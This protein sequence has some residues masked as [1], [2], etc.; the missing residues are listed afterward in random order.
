MFHRFRETLVHASVY[1]VASF[2]QKGVGFLMIPVY[3]HYLSP[4][5]Y[6]ILELID[7]F[8]VLVTM[9]AAMGLG[10]AIVRF[11]HA[12][13]DET[14]KREVA[15]TA[16]A[17]V[18]VLV[19]VLFLLLQGSTQ[20]VSNWIFQSDDYAIYF[21]I[22][23]FTVVLQTLA[24]VPESVLLAQKRS[25]IISAITLLTFVSYLSLNI[26]FIVGLKMGVMGMLLSTVITKV[27]NTSMN[28]WV[29][30]GSFVWSFSVQKFRAMAKFGMPLIP[31]SLAML[32]IHYADRFFVQRYGSADELGLYSL[33]YKF[34]MIL[35]V[36]ISQ[37]IFNIFN[38]LRFEMVDD[39][40]PGAGFGRI[41]TYIFII[42]VYAA[43]GIIVLSPE[44]INI[45]AP[46]DYQGA[47]AVVTPIVVS[48][49]FFGAQNF[50]TSGMFIGYKTGYLPVVTIGTA[51]AN[52]L[53]NLVLVPA[54]GIVGAAYSTLLTFAILA[55]ATLWCS[56]KVYHIQ[57]EV[58][59]L[60]KLAGVAACLYG[61]CCL[62][63]GNL[64]L[65]I[66]VKA[67]L[68]AC[69][70]PALLVVGFFEAEELDKAKQ[71]LRRNLP[72]PF[73]SKPKAQA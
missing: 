12:E 70:V 48:Y 2:L 30:R 40:D 67:L 21:R 47:A 55:A 56:Q 39:D 5:D 41:F 27:F 50:F 73:G 3:T 66:L 11:Y 49:V 35:S 62:V 45:M 51:V 57:F 53:L 44:A 13:K 61:L 26:L 64:W 68:L 15:S 71:L 24:T 4:H 10:G 58:P 28:F 17:G 14:S 25:K 31:T 23:A 46:D 72:H 69:F 16:L 7:L 18:L 19:G 36:L 54:F 9:L 52:A 34:G 65:T 38:T 8:V 6:G 20:T 1:S 63:G 42:M 60:V 29:A 43:L 59:R 32:A 33:G 37:P 22:V